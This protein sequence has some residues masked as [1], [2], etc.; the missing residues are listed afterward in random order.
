MI[1]FDVVTMEISSDSGD[2]DLGR[3]G[4]TG[5]WCGFLGIDHAMV[6]ALLRRKCSL[7]APYSPCRLRVGA[8]KL[9]SAW[10]WL[11]SVQRLKGYG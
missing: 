7:V 3:E 11:F 10:G 5:W 4:E 8:P 6:S 1:S 2:W 9:N